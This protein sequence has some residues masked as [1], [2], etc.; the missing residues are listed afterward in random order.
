MKR[1]LYY[2]F[3]RSSN[4]YHNWFESRSRSFGSGIVITAFWGYG[5][6]ALTNLILKC[7]FD[8][9][10]NNAII[11]STLLLSLIITRIIIKEDT[12]QKYEQ[13]FINEKHKTFHGYLVI[14]YILVNVGLF[15]LSLLVC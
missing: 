3:Y 11:I 4:F 14:M 1:F 2:I 6:L 5:L 12:A 9:K 15:V 8:L 13:L 10:T 7:L